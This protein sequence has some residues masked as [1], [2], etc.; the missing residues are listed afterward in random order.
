MWNIS[1]PMST[2]AT[3]RPS[4]SSVAA[5]V[6]ATAAT[7]TVAA[8]TPPITTK[9]SAEEI[10]RWLETFAQCVREVDYDRAREMF[11]LDV[12]GFGTF[13]AMLIGREA[14]IDGQW[15]NIWGCTR[16]FHFLLDAAHADVST[17]GDMAFVATPW[18]S[19]GR[20]AAGNW[21]DRLGRC[22]LVLRKRT[23]D[24]AWLCIH[25]HYSRQPIPEKVGV[26][27]TPA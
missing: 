9:S 22:T 19:Q 26:G 1:F 10:R 27:V 14:L 5:A 20:D 18:I 12:V 16:G 2:V 13:A 4:S 6:V 3:A 7:A 15:K 21:Y 17:D 8:A 23:R 11:D 24:G 25:S